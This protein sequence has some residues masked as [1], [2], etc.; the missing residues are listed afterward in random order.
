MKRLIDYGYLKS[1][2]L[3]A[4]FKKVP[5]H[6][7]IAEDLRDN[8]YVD[9][10]LPTG[11]GQTISAP[12]MIAIMLEVLDLKPGQKI[13]E[14]GAGSGYNA[15]LIAEVIGPNGK[16][17]TIERI[18]EIAKVGKE[19]LEKTGY[20]NVKI[21]I[22]DGTLGY[23]RAAPWD[24]IIVTACS[25]EVPKTLISQLKIGGKLAAPVGRNYMGQV[26]VTV[27]RESYKKNNIERYGGCSFV[28]LIGKH[29]WKE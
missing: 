7:F 26:L 6:R 4:A 18:K 15:A 23:K 2:D 27:E 25:P 24:R 1:P 13:L 21:L 11:K 8:A 12:S 16:L 9:Q 20:K 17:Y 5:R 14:I 19:N 29:G 22:G 3:I 28:P 10:P